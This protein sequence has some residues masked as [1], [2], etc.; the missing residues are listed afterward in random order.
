[1]LAAMPDSPVFYPPQDIFLSKKIRLIWAHPKA[2]I[3]RSLP[4]ESEQF[5]D[6]GM[7]SWF[8]VLLEAAKNPTFHILLGTIMLII[9][10]WRAHNI[11]NP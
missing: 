7:G 2:T 5:P 1:M 9:G 10:S 11:E 3:P 8:F 4:T 6:G